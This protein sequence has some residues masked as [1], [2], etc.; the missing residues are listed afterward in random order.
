MSSSQD[1]DGSTH[2]F[3][4]MDS[5]DVV[6]SLLQE[7]SQE[8]EGHDDVLSELVI[9]HLLVTDSNVQVGDLLELPLDGSLDVIDLLDEWLSMGD[10]C[11]ELTNSCEDWSTK[12]SWDFLDEGIGGDEHVVLLGP[13][14]D[15]LLVLVELLE[16]VDV[17]NVKAESGFAGFIGVFLIGNEAELEAG[18]WD[19]WES[20][21]SNETLIFLWVVVLK[22][23]L[24]L[25]SLLELSGLAALSHFS[26]LL[27]HFRVGDF[28]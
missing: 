17:G 15:E 8:V 4:D 20:D 2:S 10:W 14:L 26:D 12:S 7:G 1:S 21:L 28:A 25:D 24:E 13:S 3:L 5:F 27:Q 19:V 23:N 22:G 6:P 9:S 18:S 16:V 11:W